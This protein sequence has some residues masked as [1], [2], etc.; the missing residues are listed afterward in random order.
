M[1]ARARAAAAMVVVAGLC[2][3]LSGCVVI[4]G[5]SSRQLEVIGDV[6]IH[7]DLCTA[8][9]AAIT[10]TSREG[11]RAAGGGCG[12]PAPSNGGDQRAQ[13]LLGYRLPAGTEAPETV[14]ASGDVTGTYSRSPSYTAWLAGHESTPEGTRWQGYVSEPV[15]VPR[16]RETDWSVTIQVPLPAGS[17]SGEP[18]RG[19]LPFAVV[20]GE[21][22]LA[23]SDDPGGPVTC[24]EASSPTRCD[25]S[26][27]EGVQPTRDL[28]LRPPSDEVVVRR[29]ESVRA[30]FSAVFA[31]E[32]SPEASFALDAGA[33]GLGAAPE[34]A[35][36]M[37]AA[38][39]TTPLAVR[40]SVPPDAAL[41]AHPVT[42]TASLANGRR[43]SAVG[44]MVVVAAVRPDVAAEEPGEGASTPRRPSARAP[45]RGGPASSVSRARLG[46]VLRA[47]PRTR[48]GGLVALALT[49][50]QLQLGA[51][52]RDVVACLRP[53]AR[54]RYVRANHRVRLVA[55]RA[56]Y[57]LGD[58]RAARQPSVRVWLR[59]DAGARGGLLRHLAAAR[60]ANAGRATARA[61]TRVVPAP[62]R[63]RHPRFAG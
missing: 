38:D 3:V 32:S 10:A 9:G 8:E 39:S 24:S 33:D 48:P 59:V 63:P 44:R 58:V 51:V 31:G 37:P 13:A 21:R 12:A 17:T 2:L 36:F 15:D 54:T 52:A 26:R 56:C 4:R 57:A 28:A 50:R 53:P 20:A 23:D 61:S 40:V 6:E 45:R 29:G 47:A 41:G 35:S 14:R 49:A 46:L 5:D 7:T 34:D 22:T 27:D 62:A 55:G 25:T 30:P 43:R 16:D 1:R 11:A 18:Y 42:L 60:A 19:P